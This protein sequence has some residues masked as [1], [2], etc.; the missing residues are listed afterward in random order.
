MGFRNSEYRLCCN[1]VGCNGWLNLQ[2]RRKCR[3]SSLKPHGNFQKQAEKASKK[4]KKPAV[5]GYLQKESDKTGRSR[6]RDQKVAGSNPATSTPRDIVNQCS[7]GF[8]FPAGFL[9]FSCLQPPGLQ[10]SGE[11]LVWQVEKITS[12]I[13]RIFP[14]FSSARMSTLKLSDEILRST[15]F[16]LKGE[17]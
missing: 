5:C 10:Q 7:R 4:R 15:R 14:V 16:F 1:P 12:V 3:M 8:A 11:A 6:I 9:Y 17:P 2:K 13:F